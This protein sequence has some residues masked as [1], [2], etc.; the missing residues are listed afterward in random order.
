M[1]GRHVIVPVCL[2]G[3]VLAGLHAA[4]Q[5]VPKMHDRAMHAVF[6]LGMYKDLESIR[7]RCSYC[8]KSAP[9]QAPLPPHALLRPDYPFQIVV[10]DYCAIKGKTWL[11][12]ADRF[13]ERPQPQTWS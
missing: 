4:H 5:G 3:E 10:M 13:T 9:T 7:N 2:R 12:S 11:I 6:W 8:N 1:Y